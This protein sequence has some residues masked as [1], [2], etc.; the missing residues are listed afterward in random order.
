MVVSVKIDNLAFS[1]RLLSA[2]QPVLANFCE[3]NQHCWKRKGRMENRLDIA[4]SFEHISPNLS[5][6]RIIGLL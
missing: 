5:A 6:R 4:L 2:T 1:Q 3:A